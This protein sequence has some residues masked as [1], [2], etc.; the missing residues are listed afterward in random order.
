MSSSK[1][2]RQK[3]QNFKPDTHRT[4][5]FQR[6][7]DIHNEREGKAVVRERN[8]RLACF[9]MTGVASLLAGG[10]VVLASSSRVEPFYV[11]INADGYTQ[12]M[13]MSE[14]HDAS[15]KV[16]EIRYHL[17]QYVDKIRTIPLDTVLARK[18]YDEACA[19]L[20]KPALA[21]LADYYAKEENP[22]LL[23][24]KLTRSVKI[25]N[26]LPK[27]KDSYQVDWQE[28]TRDLDGRPRE[29]SRW[30]G[31]FTV[32]MQQPKDEETLFKNPLGIYI[33]NFS[34]AKSL[35]K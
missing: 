35:Q 13:P 17:A 22:A 14:V 18:R 16:N 32:A 20:T 2:L 34:W 30:S 24:G 31:L 21:V 33:A 23:L 1:E 3:P 26:V 29:T 6:A 19:Y 11:R 28:E 15:P 25:I 8:W 4:T 27:S 12:V 10:L 7:E 9:G 5:P